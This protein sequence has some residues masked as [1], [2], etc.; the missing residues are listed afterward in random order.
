MDWP[1]G[2]DYNEAIQH[3]A[4]A[5]RDERLQAGAAETTRLG[6]PRVRS[7]PFGNVYC[8]RG[9]G[10]VK[11]VRV[12]LFPHLERE[13]RYRAIAEHLSVGR[14][15]SFVGFE[16]QVEG[17]RVGGTWYPILVMDWA[18]GATLDVWLEERLRGCDV[19]AVGQL[20]DAWIELVADLKTHRVAHGDLQHGNVLVGPSGSLTLV[21]YDGVCVPALVGR[22]SQENGLPAYQHPGRKGRPLSLDLDDFSAWIIATSL[23]ALA[24]DPGL[25]TP[26]VAAR[27]QNHLLFSEDDLQ[28]PNESSVWDAL[29]ASPDVVVREW[30]RL[31]RFCLDEG[32]DRVPAFPPDSLSRRAVDFEPAGG[33]PHS[34]TPLQSDRP[35]VFISHSTYDRDFVEREIIPTLGAYGID[36]WYSRDD[37]QTAARW[38][39]AILQGLKACD[40]FMIVMSR[41]AAQSEWVCDEVSWAMDNRPGRIVPILLEDCDVRDFHIRM[42]RIQ[43]V[44]YRN[45]RQSARQRLLAVWRRKPS[46]GDPRNRPIS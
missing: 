30:S 8:L 40:W 6:V 27:G 33:T 41:R 10:W 1:S 34:A 46:A 37:I 4:R 17:I 19:V 36:V 26:F 23:R 15:R 7:G 12:F 3:P 42:A 13:L 43:H 5:F 39:R 2:V 14:P 9:D 44:D 31:L 28:R 22:A 11:A 20:A 25:W 21:D 24:A 18:H 38:E 45:D 29:N 16:Y 32:F 35:K